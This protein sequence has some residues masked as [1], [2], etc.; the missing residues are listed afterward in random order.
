[1][2]MEDRQALMEA[3]GIPTTRWF[4]AVVADPADV[5][6]PDRLRGMVVFGQ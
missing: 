4:D 3:K 2:A 1:M 5:D 6:Q